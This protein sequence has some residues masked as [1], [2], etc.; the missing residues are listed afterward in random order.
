MLVL[1]FVPQSNSQKPAHKPAASESGTPATIQV[2]P[3][4]PEVKQI[5]KFDCAVCHGDTGNGQGDI[6]K[7][8]NLL[9]W[10]NPTTLANKTDQQLIE[11]SG[12]AVTRCLPR[13][14]P[15]PRMTRSR[16]W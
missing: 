6:G 14:R 7:T 16:V 3:A 5:Y 4:R 9:D 12:R 15:A 11:A 8:M 2:E 10:T 1:A 13:I